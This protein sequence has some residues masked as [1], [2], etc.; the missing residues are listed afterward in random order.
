MKKGEE[1]EREA[2]GGGV[3]VLLWLLF[4]CF[5]LFVCFVCLLFCVPFSCVC[6]CVKKK[7]EKAW[8]FLACLIGGILVLYSDPQVSP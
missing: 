1:G 7:K 8:P 5:L 6:V 3:D 2:T 4:P